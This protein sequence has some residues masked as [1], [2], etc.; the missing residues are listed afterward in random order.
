[1]SIFKLST[2]ANVRKSRKGMTRVLRSYSPLNQLPNGSFK[3]SKAFFT[4]NN[5]DEFALN[6][7]VYQN[8]A[9][10]AVVNK[11]GVSM[12]G[13]KGSKKSQTFTS[14]ILQNEILV[15]T[16]VYEPVITEEQAVNRA[17]EGKVN[18]DGTPE[19]RKVYGKVGF[20]LTDDTENLFASIDAS[21]STDEEKEYLKGS[22]EKAY[23]VTFTSDD[24][25]NVETHSGDKEPLDGAPASRPTFI[26]EN[27]MADASITEP[28][29]ETD[30]DLFT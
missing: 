24:T 5:L 15:K 3:V 22:I 1:M 28:E 19:M 25:E 23:I 7:F 30:E 10:L 21:S 20:T 27:P 13:Q 26:A 4:E 6:Y 2:K 18:A 9:Y 14:T 12:T 8:K 29:F 16:G 17:G 11:D